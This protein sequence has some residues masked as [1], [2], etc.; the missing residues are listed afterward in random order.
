MQN[1]SY[2]IGQVFFA[3]CKSVDTPVSLGVWLRYKHAEFTQLASKRI[4]PR[5][6]L[7]PD[8]FARDYLVTSYLSKYRGLETGIDTREAALQG[9]AASEVK[10]GEVNRFLRKLSAGRING[11]NAVIFT[12]A[13]KIR[14]LLGPFS[15]FALESGMGFGPGATNDLRRGA[16]LLDTKLTK[17]PLSVSSKAAALA[18]SV[19]ETDLHWSA[20]ILNV[21][22]DQIGGP[23]SLL[24]RDVFNLTDYGVLD[25]VPK[26]ALTDRV[27]LKEPRLNAFLQKGVGA[28]FRRKLRSVGIDLDSQEF[29]Q[30]AAF[31]CLTDELVTLDLR[32]ASDSISSELIYELLPVDWALALDDLRSKLC[33]MP[34]GTMHRLEKF[35]S[36][37]NGFTFELETIVFWAIVKAVCELRESHSEVLVYGDDIICS[38]DVSADVI[39][40][41]VTLGFQVN[42]EKS[43]V[44]GVFYESCGKHYF[45]QIDVTPIY[46]K[47]PLIT[48]GSHIRAYNRLVR[49]GI[50]ASASG[51]Y[52]P[53]ASA[54]DHLWRTRPR[55]V[56]RCLIPDFYEGDDGY[57]VDYAD[58]LPVSVDANRGFKVNV[59]Q[60]RHR[61]LPACDDAF[62]ALRLR[63]RFFGSGYPNHLDLLRNPTL[64][65][66]LPFEGVVEIPLAET[67]AAIGTRWIAH[68]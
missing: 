44:S 67:S 57:L 48:E 63:A 40:A 42:L 55:R 14:Q 52:C 61:R 36:M 19:I 29:N 20:C 11:P 16:A 46:Q 5:D 18:A 51:L 28:Y 41:L 60:L 32:A 65:V 12:A 35:S 33:R 21:S 13:R 53:V 47:E 30:E 27:I 54:V 23:Y 34:D 25:T 6:Y 68:L 62:L 4:N 7:T 43:F 24:Q 31:R 9:F 66:P 39:E 8:S 22:V 15:L 38:C 1:R 49:Y 3:L 45:E 50:R 58:I 17:V 56:A 2:D 10:C 59:V 37:G 26:N 64:S